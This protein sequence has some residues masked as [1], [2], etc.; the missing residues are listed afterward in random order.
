MPTTPAE[1]AE[2]LLRGFARNRFG[3][4]ALGAVAGRERLGIDLLELDLA[5]EHFGFP[6]L[7]RRLIGLK[8]GHHGSKKATSAEW[9]KAVSPKAIFASGDYV[10]AH[11]YCEAIDRAIANTKL[12]PD[13]KHFYC[14][15]KDKD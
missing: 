11:P 7:M 14:C 5:V 13:K 1:A 10:W 6:S 15:G 9:V 4:N 3:R 8:L 2:P 12:D